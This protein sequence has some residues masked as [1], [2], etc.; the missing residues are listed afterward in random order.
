MVAATARPPDELIAYL[1]PAGGAAT[2]ETIAANAVMAGCLPEYMSTVIAA[3]EALAIPDFNL[4]GIQTTTNPVGPAIIVNGPIR[5]TIGINCQRGLLG[6]GWRANA[7][8]GRAVRLCMLH[9]GGAAP[10]TVD[11]ALHGMPGK[12]TFCFGEDEERSPW[13]PLHVERGFAA[14]ESVVTC[15]GAI[16]TANVLAIY[17]KAESVL[18]AVADTLGQVGAN[19]V[20]FQHGNPLVIMS[21]GHAN[22]LQSQGYD[23]QRTK[24]WLYEHAKVPRSRFPDEIQALGGRPERRAISEEHAVAAQPEDIV[25]VVAGGDEPYHVTVCSN[26]GDTQMTSA[27]VRDLAV[28]P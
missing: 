3:V 13:P 21:Y 7:T 18:L 5:R 14:N 22:L 19:N 9:I 2:I 24:E 17:K 12:Y 15:V 25:L 26:F 8:I 11:Q 1:D 4:H 27:V 20:E 6:P 28:A 16:G 23:K 10:G